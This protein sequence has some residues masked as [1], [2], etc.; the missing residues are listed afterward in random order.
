MKLARPDEFK[1]LAREDME[2]FLKDQTQRKVIAVYGTHIGMMYW[3]PGYRNFKKYLNTDEIP[4]DLAPDGWKKYEIG[5][6]GCYDCPV[7][8]KDIYRIPDGRRSGEI[9][10]A[11]EFECID[12]LGTNCG[13]IDPIAIMEME[14]LTEYY[15][16]HGYDPR[17]GIH[18][19]VHALSDRKSIE[20]L[21][22]D[23]QAVLHDILAIAVIERHG[24]SGNIGRVLHM[25][26]IM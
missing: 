3:H 5:R 1:Q 18:T 14:M 12:C 15:R 4:D 7:K 16:V 2:F 26:R 25:T 9:G 17:T 6:T 8:C 23:G 24:K 10:S 11:L 22:T 13:I 20:E 21:K 19:E